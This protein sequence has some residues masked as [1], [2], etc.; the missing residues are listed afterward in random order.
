VSIDATGNNLLNSNVTL[1]DSDPPLS[2]P[3]QGDNFEVNG[4][5]Y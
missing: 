1:T 4:T 3:I 5:I 2:E